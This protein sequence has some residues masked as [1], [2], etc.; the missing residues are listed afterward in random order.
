[1]K[2]KN[3]YF[4]LY[5]FLLIFILFQLSSCKKKKE[6]AEEIKNLEAIITFI[7]GDAYIL[8]EK[9]I[10]PAVIG[11][12]LKEGDSLKTASDS[13]IEILIT[14]SSV[15]RMDENTELSIERLSVTRTNSDIA[16]SLLTGSIVNKVEKIIAPPAEAGSYSIRTQG[17][18]LGVRGTEFLISSLEPEKVLLAVKSGKVHMIPHPDVVERLKE[19]APT[20]DTNIEN[21][22]KL[23]EE[24]FPDVT[25]GSE[26]TIAPDLSAEILKTLSIVE[27]GLDDLKSEKIP[28]KE[29]HE[30]I[31]TSSLATVSEAERTLAMVKNIDNANIEKLKI[32]DFMQVH[33]KNEKFKEVIF[34]TDPAGAKI[35]FDNSFIGHG[36]ISALL[37]ENRTVSVTAEHEGY[38]PFEKEFVISE[39]TEKPYIITLK[40]GAPARGYFEISVVPADAE[41]LIGNRLVG[42]GVYRGS[43]DPGTKLNVSL[44]RKEYKS[45][46]LSVE[47]KEGETVKRSIALPV[48]L[49]PYSFDTGF[50]KIDKIVS[51]GRSFCTLV[52]GK[53]GFS[54]IDAEG[55]TLF[56]NS[57]TLTAT[58]VFAGGKLLFIS[59]N[60]FK[61]IDTAGWKEAGN[62]E[63]EESLYRVPVVDGN[64]VLINSGDSILVIDNNDFKVS[65][66]IKVPDSVVSYPYLSNNRILTV[67]DKGVLQIFGQEETPVSSIPITLGNP[68]GVSIAIGNNLGYFANLNGSINA[69]DLQTGNFLWG[70]KYQPDASGNLPYISASERGIIIY[71]NNALKFFKLNGEEIKEIEKVKSFCLGENSLVYAAS[72]NGRI[73]AY[74]SMTGLAVRYADTALPI[75]SIVFQNGKIHAA[76]ENGKYVIINP[77]AFKQ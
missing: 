67:T 6:Q 66:K 19:K 33:D 69:I 41:I 71:S 5:L 74:N 36:S 10:L 21:F 55:K 63:L 2:K 52:S 23:V 48:L 54:V 15:I 31:S 13:Y 32:T 64:S 72:E 58:P 37:A 62:I 25:G 47:I 46:E 49:V 42:K 44:Q 51:A 61:A 22:I 73:T 3:I 77:A 43:F 59:E 11:S 35:Y 50:D 20:G 57:D 9:G 26:I 28:M 1:M 34:R 18:V 4:L 65:R 38:E 12:S 75:E 45:E 24:S 17:A 70:G 76:T 30:I 40:P 53:N 27:K 29:L 14:G 60:L 68:G 39:I 56:K 8:S 16:M 7:S